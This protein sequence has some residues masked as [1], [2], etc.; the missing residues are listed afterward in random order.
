MTS[1]WV[2]FLVTLC[3]V[4]LDAVQSDRSRGFGF[5][6]MSTVEEATRCI[7]ELNGVVCPI[8]FVEFRSLTCC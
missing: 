2:K 7:Q 3:Y 4:S 5:I 1:G 8:P 6:E